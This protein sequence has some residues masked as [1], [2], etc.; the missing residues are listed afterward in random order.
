MTNASAS[1][2]RN[3]NASRNATAMDSIVS[4][5]LSCLAGGFVDAGSADPG[6]ALAE[7]VDGVFVGAFMRG[8]SDFK[9]RK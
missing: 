8:E 6:L 4:R 3:K 5:I 1:K 7:G 9:K 2:A